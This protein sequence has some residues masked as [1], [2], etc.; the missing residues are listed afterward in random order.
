MNQV[1]TAL[2]PL[3]PLALMQGDSV[4]WPTRDHEDAIGASPNTRGFVAMLAAY[5]STG[6]I[7]RGA[8]L[9]WLLDEYPDMG[10][11]SLASLVMSGEVFGFEWRDTFWVPMFQFDQ[12]DMSVKQGPKQ[13]RLALDME[14]D[15]WALSAWF[16]QGNGCLRGKRPV[17]VITPNL[18][19]VV[20]A[21]CMDRHRGAQN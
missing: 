1:Q 5:R 14:F 9:A 13:V 21:A 17:D 19:A 10:P 18:S 12:R 6:G 8:D 20:A 11:G 4:Q 7:E 2:N 3:I 15:R 16:A